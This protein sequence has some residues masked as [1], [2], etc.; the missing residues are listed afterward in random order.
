ML[1]TLII[2]ASGYAGI[3]L[4]YYLNKHSYV[5]ILDLVVSSNS[6]DLGKSIDELYPQMK[7]IINLKLKSLDQ[8]MKTNKKIDVVFLAT[9]PVTSHNL[10]HFFIKK[11][12]VVLD[13]SG[14]FR[15]NNVN[16]YKKYYGFVHNY[17][18]LL[19]KS[20]YGLAEW[21][22]KNISKAQ[23][24]AVPGCYPTAA[25]LSLKPL[26][27]SKYLDK[28]YYP[29]INAISGISGAGRKNI[30]NNNFCEVSLNAYNLFKHRHEP[31][32]SYY[33]G[34]PIIFTP[35]IGNFS[36]GILSTITCK[37]KSD[38]LYEDILTIF[39]K[40]YSN[41]PLIRIYDNKKTPALKSVINLPFIDIGFSIKG[42]YLIIIAAEDNLLKGAATQAIQCLN[43]RFGFL[44]TESIL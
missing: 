31:E 41:E 38:M 9:D 4:V 28:K 5:K 16:F 20:T 21:N 6:Q 18:D 12:C 7:K 44:E 24:I 2:G 42:K 33:L 34:I 1:N 22:K 37:V 29:V 19:K 43:I 30:L 39:K 15:I 26:I 14:A 10:V 17:T 32:I 3:E 36:R 23:L 35:H 8:A 25:L 40:F 11:K 27:E 13:L